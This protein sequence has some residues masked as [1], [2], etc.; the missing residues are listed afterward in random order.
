MWHSC[1]LKQEAV[2]RK[3]VLGTLDEE[4]SLTSRGCTARWSYT[5]AC[6]CFELEP[7]QSVGTACQKAFTGEDTPA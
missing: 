4:P 1:P 2:G 6:E 3:T 5:C 7:E